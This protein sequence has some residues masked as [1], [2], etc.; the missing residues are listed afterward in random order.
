MFKVKNKNKLIKDVSTEY[1]STWISYLR[2][3]TADEKNH[4]LSPRLEGEET[5]KYVVSV[6]PRAEKFNTVTT[7]DTRKSPIFAWISCNTGPIFKIIFSGDL[8]FDA[9]IIGLF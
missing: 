5:L 2:K 1:F 9:L 6:G 3:I 8:F 4:P 7:M